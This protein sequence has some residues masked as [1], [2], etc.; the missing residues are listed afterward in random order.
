MS[1]DA[2][3]R[4]WEKVERTPTCWLWMG[5]ENGNGYG[6][7]S[8]DG[9]L[10]YAHRWAYASAQGPIPAGRVVDHLCRVPRCVR[11]SHLELVEKGE[12]TARGTLGFKF[13][14]TCRAGLHDVTQESAVYVRPGGGRRCR[15]CH[16]ENNKKGAA[17]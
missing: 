15:A 9:R 7:F 1:R 14:G 11:P 10:V 8:V 16:Y 6:R 13:D 2:A 4:F 17:A 12:N 5:G 3:T